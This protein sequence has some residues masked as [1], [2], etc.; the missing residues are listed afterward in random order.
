MPVNSGMRGLSRW[1]F[2]SL[3]L[4]GAAACEHGAPFTAPSPIQVGPFGEAVPRRLTF[5]E[6]QDETP[7]VS[8]GMLYFSRQSADEPG[9]YA[10]TG[11]EQCI[12]IMPADGGTIVR[13]LCPRDYIVQPDTFVDTW[14]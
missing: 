6:G 10:A 1:C 4:G 7:I 5:F 3:L 11:R 9:A 13:S 12:A 14:F 8:G 2:L